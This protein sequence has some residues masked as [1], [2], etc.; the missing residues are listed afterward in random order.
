[1]QVEHLRIKLHF[2]IL[3][4]HFYY[5]FYIHLCYYILE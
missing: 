3:C 4:T 1:M 2:E 5:L